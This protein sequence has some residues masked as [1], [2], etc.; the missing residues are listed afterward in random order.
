M[1]CGRGDA[2]ESGVMKCV[3]LN[4]SNVEYHY[5][6]WAFQ[7][8]RTVPLSYI[9]S[10]IAENRPYKRFSAILG[11]SIIIGL[12]ESRLYQWFADSQQEGFQANFQNYKLSN[13]VPS[14]RLR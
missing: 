13:G 9:K 2:N 4:F 10:W 3:Y 1:R 6:S 11:Q 7:D 5:L 14:L 8:R 12:E